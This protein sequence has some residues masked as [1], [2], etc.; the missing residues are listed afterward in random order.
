MP[1]GGFYI[2][3]EGADEL[4]R[5]LEG[6]ER[7]IKDLSKAHR[8]IGRLAAENVR[9]HAPVGSGSSKD[10]AGHAPPGFLKARTTG[11]GGKAGAYVQTVTEPFHYLYVQEFG[12]TSFWHKGA[13]GSLRAANRAHVSFARLGAKG[14][15][16]Y[17]KARNSRGYFIWNVAWR[18]QDVLARQYEMDLKQIGAANDLDIEF[19]G[20]SLGLEPEPKP[21]G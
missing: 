3:V 9:K 16:I 19:T 12:G 1:V 14:H 15:P 4:R 18:M 2:E 8:A 17:K 5:A 10:G 7:G 6:T 21:G 20:G 13:A 11:G